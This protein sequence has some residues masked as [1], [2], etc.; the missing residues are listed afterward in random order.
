M[1][2]LVRERDDAE[3]ILTRDALDK[4]KRA[5]RRAAPAAAHGP[6][7]AIVAPTFKEAAN[8]RPLLAKLD[9][10]L[11]D[12][13]FEVIFVDDN[14]PDGTADLVREIARTRPNLRCIQRIGRRGLAS[15][16]IEGIMATA[17]PFVAVIDADMQ[18]DER[19]L[20]DMLA[21]MKTG[22][23]DV[24]VGSRYV[25]GGGMGD[26]S[27]ARI[28]L[29]EFA[30]AIGRRILRADL[31]DPMSGFF[32]VR[33]AFFQA[34]VP[35]LSNEGFKIL[36]DLF[37]SSPTTPRFKELP[38]E[39]RSR[40]HGESKLDAKV[41]LDY[42]Q[43]VV[44]KLTGGMIPPRFI[45]FAAVGVGGLILHMTVLWLANRLAGESFAAAQVSATAVAIIFNYTF[46]NAITYRDRRRLG[47]RFFTGL[48]SFGLICS[49]GAIG[50]VGV[51]NALFHGHSTWWLAGAAGAMVG[52][53]WNYAMSSA[54]T[55]KA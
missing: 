47:W 2:D 37:A 41:A 39:F 27:P 46:N 36:F 23:Y 29:S 26:W 30:S 32:M 31:T 42:V 53:V 55:W 5:D 34:A 52:A 21:A 13:P 44:S 1:T 9:A 40:E 20:T 22:A 16:C 3:L 12:E 11:G 49:I 10:A 35:H 48:L 33:R 24:V 43:L 6:A 18:H 14:S 25:Q 19:L 15:A 45:F 28:R 51:A 50:N 38:Y 54:F 17:A 4:R 8:I 7:L